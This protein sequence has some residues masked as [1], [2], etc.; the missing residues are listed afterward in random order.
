M[1]PLTEQ[2]IDANVVAR[3]FQPARCSSG[4]YFWSAASVPQGELW[5]G[6]F[7]GRELFDR[8]QC[9]RFDRDQWRDYPTREAAFDDLRNAIR[10]SGT[11]AAQE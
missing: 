1:N 8:L 2:Q 10:L 11:N 4:R 5:P 6:H 7:L 9:G 3:G